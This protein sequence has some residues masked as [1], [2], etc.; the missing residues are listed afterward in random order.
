V[1]VI[2]A[3]KEQIRL[4]PQFAAVAATLGFLWRMDAYDRAAYSVFPAA[5]S[6]T[7]SGLQ[8]ED[9]LKMIL[10]EDHRQRAGD[11]AT[12]L[13]PGMATFAHELPGYPAGEHPACYAYAAILTYQAFT[14]P[15]I[16]KARTLFLHGDYSAL[17]PTDATAT[18]QS[19]TTEFL[20]R[21]GIA[22][23]S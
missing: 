8:L 10:A 7:F 11:A 9:I 21:G 23:Q 1:G 2:V 18:E 15:E 20:T 19:K 3:A 14:H 4:Q 17:I 22:F 16:Q 13:N 6:F 12:T 5:E